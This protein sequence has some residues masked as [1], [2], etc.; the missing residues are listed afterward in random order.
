[1]ILNDFEKTQK[2]RNRRAASAQKEKS[3]LGKLGKSATAQK[4]TQ[5]CS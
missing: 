5:K 3:F 2:S 1:M 4:A